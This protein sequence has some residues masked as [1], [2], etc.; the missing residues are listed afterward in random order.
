VNLSP[1]QIETFVGQCPR[2]WALQY[3]QKIK[4]PQAASAARGDVIHKMFELYGSGQDPF[5]A[6][7]W[8][9]G[10]W[11][12]NL[13]AD[14]AESAKILLS[15]A[16]ESGDLVVDASALIEQ[17][18]RLSINGATI[19]GRI[20]RLIQRPGSIPVVDD[21]KTTKD[22]KWAETTGTLA[23]KWPMRLYAM[24]L[25]KR[26]GA[27]Q[28]E[29]SHI[30]LQVKKGA[31]RIR[32][33]A[34]V[35]EAETIQ[36]WF[37]ELEGIIEE[38]KC[39]A[40]LPAADQDTLPPVTDEA[41]QKYGGCPF[42]PFCS[43]MKTKAEL[44]ESFKPAHQPNPTPS[45]GIAPMNPLALAQAHRATQA[46]ATLPVPTYRPGVA[47]PTP[48]PTPTPAPLPV[49]TYRAAP[50]PVAEAPTA[51]APTP[52]PTATPVADFLAQLTAAAPAPT[53][54]EPVEAAPVE[55]V[56]PVAEV[57]PV[58][59]AAQPT[60]TYQRGDLV[61]ATAR[62]VKG[63]KGQVV[64]VTSLTSA[65]VLFE[66]NQRRTLF[67]FCD[68]APATVEAP[69]EAPTESRY[70]PSADGEPAP[71]TEPAAPEPVRFCAPEAPPAVDLLILVNCSANTPEQTSGRE[72][73]DSLLHGFGTDLKGFFGIDAFKRRD[74]LATMPFDPAKV[75]TPTLIHCLGDS[76]DEKAVVFA[77]GEKAVCVYAHR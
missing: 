19:F 28:V 25:W 55:P 68:L 64:E 32:R 14:E 40:G 57:A 9:D 53:P 66:G 10:P 29:I 63:R 22:L 59:V 4:P 45:Q 47:A 49:P 44:I 36:K 12:A 8:P 33:V 54:V 37:E 17:E 11:S 39:A 34:V 43:R 15:K 42:V 41:C 61:I 16:A 1:T 35:V 56:E 6:K 76:S 67:D 38:M 75:L 3:A 58:E 7:H 69:V 30:Y 50:P 21:F 46:A 62:S 24:W 20:D 60:R 18:L 74:L 48:A 13:T 73:L 26:T 31:E 72:A 71:A 5:D 65:Y 70:E 51:P 2:K 23:E 52:T 77:I 27:P